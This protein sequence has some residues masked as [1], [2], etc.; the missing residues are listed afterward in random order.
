MICI[1]VRLLT[2]GWKS[3][4]QNWPQGFDLVWWEIYMTL[5]SRSVVSPH[6]VIKCSIKL[7]YY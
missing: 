1:F 4:E 2:W 7:F 6:I 5:P 3:Y